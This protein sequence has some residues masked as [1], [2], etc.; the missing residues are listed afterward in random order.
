VNK[1]SR[2]LSSELS[3]LAEH[4]ALCPPIPRVPRNPFVCVVSP[5]GS[6][7]TW[8]RR[9]DVYVTIRICGSSLSTEVVSAST[10]TLLLPSDSFNVKQFLFL[11]S[12]LLTL[13]VHSAGAQSVHAVSPAVRLDQLAL[14]V[15]QPLAPTSHDGGETTSKPILPKTIPAEAANPDSTRLSQGRHIWSGAA[16]GALLGTGVGLAFSRREQSIEVDIGTTAYSALGAVSG[17]IVGALAGWW[18]Y[19][20]R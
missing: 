18:V 4:S 8:S 13:L 19:F 10:P 2:P 12:L 11:P 5:G 15:R 7:S 20:Q 16:I 17:A 1:K 6:S 14:G 3:R 9:K